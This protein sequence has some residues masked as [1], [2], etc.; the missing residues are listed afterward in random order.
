MERLGAG[1]HLIYKVKVQERKSGKAK[2]RLNERQKK[3]FCT[4]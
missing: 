2:N 3:C 1:R 4:D